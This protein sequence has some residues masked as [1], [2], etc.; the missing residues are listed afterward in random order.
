M[1]NKKIVIAAGTGFIGA[2]LTTY[3]GN[4]NDIVILTRHPRPS[5]GR[6]KYV[7]WDGRTPDT[8]T[9]ELEGADLLI[10]L[11][12]KSV[13]CRYTEANKR[14]IF[15]SR[16]NATSV[17]G[18]AIRSL[19]HPPA[20]WINAASATIYR[21]AEDRPMD[22][23][24]GEME[25]DFSVQV[26]KRWE[27]VFNAQEVPGTR[28]AILRIAVTLGHQGG[29]MLPYLNLVK[30]G[31]GGHQGSG[32]Q[33]FSWVHIEDVCRMMEWLYEHP[34]QEGVFNCSAPHP[35]DNREFMHTLRKAAG[36]VFGLPAFTWMLEIGARLIGTETELLLKSRWVL[37]T[38]AL[39]EGFVFTYP[40]LQPAMENII[41]KLP[42]RRYHLL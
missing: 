22:E 8:W 18:T 30:F 31:L 5:S 39:Q 20:L 37:P 4:D 29:V 13:N 26:C 33:R 24:T 38:R 14:E 12:G 41:S 36:H 3:F 27:S 2:G 21:H 28:K 25:N 1:K 7:H 15:D 11:A 19:Q 10:N 35:V 34:E 16:T 17:L 23:F 32:R 42:R 9:L 40:E 6:I